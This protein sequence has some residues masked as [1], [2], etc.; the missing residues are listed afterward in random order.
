MPVRLLTRLPTKAVFLLISLAFGM[1]TQLLYS[2]RRTFQAEEAGPVVEA[3]AAA[4]A[5]AGST[6]KLIP[7]SDTLGST[8]LCSP[9]LQPSNLPLDFTVAA[10]YD[11]SR[12]TRDQYQAAGGSLESYGPFRDIRDGLDKDYHGSYTRERQAMQDELVRRVVKDADRTPQATPWIVFTAGAMGAGKSRTIKW[13]S[14]NGIFPLRDIVHID[15][16]IFKRLFPEWKGYVRHDPMRAGLQTRHESGYLVEI[17]QEAALRR[18]QHI[19]VD[20]SLRDSDWYAHAFRQIR[21]VHP[22]Y[23]IAILYVT[24]D[25]EEIMRRA[26]RRGEATGRHVPEA[27]ILDSIHRVPLSV[28]RLAPHAE[29]LAVIDNSNSVPHLTKYCEEDMCYLELDRWEEIT[30]RLRSVPAPLEQRS[31]ASGRLCVPVADD[32]DSNY[33]GSEHDNYGH[34]FE[35]H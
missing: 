35:H 2:V 33:A 24:A 1:L 12:S 11:Y 26:R 17:A 18:G 10:D 3:A 4:N 19:W 34:P 21:R 6:G 15:P 29:F 5:P 30:E 32:T 23:Q 16:D 31:A 22:S 20:G 25:K 8:D 7:R 13:M 9:A 27:E 28:A 14:Q